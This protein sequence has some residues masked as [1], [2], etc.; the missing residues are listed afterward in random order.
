MAARYKHSSIKKLQINKKLFFYLQ[1]LILRDWEKKYQT[2]YKR[3]SYEDINT[4]RDHL[5]SSIYGK[6]G[7]KLNSLNCSGA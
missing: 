5:H 2:R 7:S 6:F 4:E 3:Q 1:T